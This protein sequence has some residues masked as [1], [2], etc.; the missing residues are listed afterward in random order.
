MG[1]L[2]GI[3]LM[4]QTTCT[5]VRY[6]G[7]HPEPC[8]DAM[9]VDRTPC[10]IR[11]ASSVVADVEPIGYVWRSLGAVLSMKAPCWRPNCR[12]TRTG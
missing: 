12:M 11:S 3:S 9:S 10:C 8:A 4:G 2:G 6:L 5:S 7:V 1:A